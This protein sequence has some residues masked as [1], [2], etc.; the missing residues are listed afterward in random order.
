MLRRLARNERGVAMVEF[1]FVMPVL[2][3]MFIGCFVVSDMISCYRKV[4]IATRALTDLVSRNVSPSGGV[5]TSAVSTYINSAGLVMSPFNT[6]KT[7]MQIT[8]MRVCDATHAYVVW[9]QAQAGTTTSTS[10]LTAGTVVVI[11]T[12]MITSPMIPTSPDGTNVCSNTAPSTATKTQVGTAGGYLFYGQVAFAYTPAVRYGA[13]T[14][15]VMGDQIYMS[16]R[17]N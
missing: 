16:P 8:L 2:L 15:T 10:S 5:S 3:V 12:K 14:T 17:L 13:L 4:T 7:T 6:S 1:A 11:P 9:T